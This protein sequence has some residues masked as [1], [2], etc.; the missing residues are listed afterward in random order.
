MKKQLALLLAV[1][2]M[3]CSAFSLAEGIVPTATEA[4]NTVTEGQGAE[5][6]VMIYLCGTDLESTPGM[7]GMA[8]GN[9]AEIA[10]TKPTDSVNVV[11]QTGGTKQWYA[12]G[13][14]LDINPKKLQRYSYNQNGYTLIEEAPLQ[15]MASADTLSDFLSWGKKTY[16]AEKY[17]LVLW[18]HGGGSVT[19]LIVDEL[20]DNAVMSLDELQRGLEQSG[21]QLE[22]LLLDTCLMAT[23]ETAQ[24]AQSTTHYMIA[25]QES[26]PG[27]GTDYKSW[28]QKL[29]DDP[30][31]DGQRFGR[32]L[33]DAVQQKYAE[34]NDEYSSKFLTYSVIDL[35]KLDAV[36]VSWTAPQWV[37]EKTARLPE[38]S[39]DDYMV[40][41]ETS[42]VDGNLHLTITNAKDAVTAVDAVIYQ[43]DPD[44]GEWIKL[45][46][47]WDVSGNFAE[48]EFAANFGGYW[49]ALN[50]RFCQMSVQE[51]ADTY[52]LYNIP[53]YIEDYK[54]TNLRAALMLYTPLSQQAEAL[55]QSDTAETEESAAQDAPSQTL[56]SSVQPQEDD[57]ADGAGFMLDGPDVDGV[58]LSTLDPNGYYQLF[59]VYCDMD[60][61][62]N[63]PGRDTFAMQELAGRK[64]AL[65]M[66]AVDIETGEELGTGMGEMFDI[67]DNM[68]MD[69][70]ALPKGTYAFS[71]EVKSVLGKTLTTK[72]VTFTWD[73]EK[74]T[75]E[76]ESEK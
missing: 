60:T 44:S 52:I 74:A 56:D 47:S 43:N 19:G 36:N 1:W 71:F 23:L 15:N 41:A 32:K 18:D 46:S 40:E 5:W 22:A 63:M 8:S 16:P 55:S 25:S 65:L 51:E 67:T 17:M 59:G 31:C 62:L 30:D 4:E 27:Q 13:V 68:V 6:T 24:A 66:T 76:Q 54:A 2:M 10:Q 38:V 7:G 39:Y 57:Q 21:V 69:A 12:Q 33:C 29:Y 45:G 3:L 14:G 58:D 61:A 28:L 11:L 72:P 9:L 49:A 73:G 64:M 75:F 26:V 35:T 48:G 50:G 53:A 34:L 42:I 20:H 37:Y 70:Q